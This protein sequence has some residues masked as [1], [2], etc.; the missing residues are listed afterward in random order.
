MEVQIMINRRIGAAALIGMILVILS[1]NISAENLNAPGL[2]IFNSKFNNAYAGK[3]GVPASV[4]KTNA[5]HY[6]MEERLEYNWDGGS[7]EEYTRISNTFNEYDTI[8]ST[9]VQVWVDGISDWY[10]SN[11]QF[12]QFNDQGQLIKIVWQNWTGSLWQIFLYTDISYYENGLM[13]Q[14]RSYYDE[15]EILESFT[16]DE[17]DHISNYLYQTKADEYADP[18]NVSQ[19]IHEFDVNGYRLSYTRQE[20]ESDHWVNDVMVVYDYIDVERAQHRI[21]YYENY[22]WMA[23]DWQLMSKTTYTYDIDGYVTNTLTENY[24]GSEWQAVS[25]VSLSYYGFGA[26]EE[27]FH[28][29]YSAINGWQNYKRVALKFKQFTTDVIAA[30]DN[31]PQYFQITKNYP[32]PFNIST[33]IEFSVP[34]RADLALDIY[35]VLG[36]K[37]RTLINRNMPAGNYSADWDGLD[38]RGKVVSTGVYF[39]NLKTGNQSQVRKML[40]LK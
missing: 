12:N 38:E 40:L 15:E 28:E 20:W 14:A 37:V 11:R 3:D 32:N 22:E 18:V 17:N 9:T 6:L 30:G 36:Q 5:V 25:R 8:A 21:D 39:C 26:V 7:W 19:V 1:V 35:N 2:A 24:T 16:Y 10:N 23:G 29:E 34:S 33:T 27:E 4:M 31:L 13:K